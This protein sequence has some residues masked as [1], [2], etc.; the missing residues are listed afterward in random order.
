MSLLQISDKKIET[1]ATYNTKTISLRFVKY[2]CKDK[3]NVH[4][5][6]YQKG[7]ERSSDTTALFL[8]IGVR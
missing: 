5:I 2:F 8:E 7:P 6:T 4:Q 1:Q 3:G